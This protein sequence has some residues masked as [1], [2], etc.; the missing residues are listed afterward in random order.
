L[1]D[2]NMFAGDIDGIFCNE[3]TS[4]VELTADCHSNSPVTC[5]CCTGCS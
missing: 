1:L 4:L 3:D 2:G 5:S